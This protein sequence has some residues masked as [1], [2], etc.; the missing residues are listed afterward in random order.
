[1]VDLVYWYYLYKSDW[2]EHV[3]IRR[4]KIAKTKKKIE[5]VNE[6]ETMELK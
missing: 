2:K 1:M 5:E 3:R 6:D 4:V